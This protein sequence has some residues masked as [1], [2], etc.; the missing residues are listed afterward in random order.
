MKNLFITNGF[1]PA[2]DRSSRMI[3]AVSDTQLRDHNLKSAEVRRIID[4]TFKCFKLDFT[5]GVYNGQNV[6]ECRVN[7]NEFILKHYDEL[8][9]P[10]IMTV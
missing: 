7:E 8:Y 6:K 9:F 4:Y 1:E 2:E 5:L 3:Y 10:G